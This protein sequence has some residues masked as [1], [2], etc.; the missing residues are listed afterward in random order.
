MEDFRR[1]GRRQNAGEFLAKLERGTPGVKPELV[2]TVLNNSPS[3]YKTVL[4][5]NGIGY[6]A[7]VKAR[8]ERR[9]GELIP[10]Q[11]EHGG[12]RKTESSFHHERLK[13]LN[14]SETQ[15][16]RWQAIASIPEK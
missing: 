16:H 14:I 1:T 10:E 4:N 5:E 8:A 2:N 3:E 9:A 15:S 6:M 13:D 7:E 12:D 11:I